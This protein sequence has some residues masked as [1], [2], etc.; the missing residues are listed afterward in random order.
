L[1]FLVLSCAFCLNMKFIAVVWQHICILS[2]FCFSCYIQCNKNNYI[3]GSRTSVQHPGFTWIPPHQSHAFCWPNSSHSQNCMEKIS[4]P[5]SYPRSSSV[6]Y[7]SRM[8]YSKLL[9]CCTSLWW[10]LLKNMLLL[11]SWKLLLKTVFFKKKLTFKKEN[12]RIKLISLICTSEYELFKPSYGFNGI[13][14]KPRYNE[15]YFV[16]WGQV[17]LPGSFCLVS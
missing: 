3:C 16:C 4:S 1:L 2:D 12:Y 15:M 11:L 5:P 13:N 10:E 6:A 14:Q 8:Y 7:L 17:I 9:F